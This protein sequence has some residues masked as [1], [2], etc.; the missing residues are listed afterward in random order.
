[1]LYAESNSETENSQKAVSGTNQGS[2]HLKKVASRITSQKASLRHQAGVHK[3][4]APQAT[5]RA[6]AELRAFNQDYELLTELNS[7]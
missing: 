6:R 7:S 5:E 2:S 4:M 1:M 3:S